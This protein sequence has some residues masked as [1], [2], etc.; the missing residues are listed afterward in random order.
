MITLK[1]KLFQL[2]EALKSSYWFLPSVI[3]FLSILL[4]IVS[5]KIDEIKTSTEIF[6]WIY[7]NEAEGARLILSTIAGTM[8]SIAGV[9]FSMTIMAI[10]FAS[11]QIG[12]RI[13]VGFMQD[14]GNQFTL[15]VFVSTFVYS[16][17]V[18]RTIKEGSQNSLEFVPHYSI[19][20]TI[21]LALLS[22]GVLI[23]YIHHIPQSISMVQAVHKVG[24]QFHKTIGTV[25]DIYA[26]SNGDETQTEYRD[27]Y[28]S[29]PSR[30]NIN[31]NSEGYIEYI[32]FKKIIQVATELDLI[33]KIKV[34]P[35]K[36][37][38]KE[39]QLLEI[40]AKQK[41]DDKSLLKL[42]NTVI[43]ATKRSFRQDIFFSA[44]L[45]SE[46]AI[47]ALSPS[48][49]DPYTAID[50]LNKIESGLINMLNLKKSN[51]CYFDKNR[52]IRVIYHIISFNEGFERIFD[53][54]RSY[55]TKDFLSTKKVIELFYS[56]KRRCHDPS[57]IAL[58]QKQLNYYSKSFLDNSKDSRDR[59]IIK[60]LSNISS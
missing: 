34:M 18:L 6:S 29:Y 45:L 49:N 3:V 55:V 24:N 27:F 39:C 19:L 47:R 26:Q 12:P 57:S 44:Q 54:L 30:I 14:K 41:I 23:Y 17:L 52:K 58:I 31:S 2:V 4:S 50:C 13:I 51:F 22:V 46:I 38:M 43:W 15:G 16:I 10:S 59:E 20:I 5:L 53:S 21:I 56:L 1:R 32:D 36:Y 25:K 37:I 33:I 60:S 48:M 35:G 9:T 40:Y 8:M 42:R 11:S 28:S 7:L